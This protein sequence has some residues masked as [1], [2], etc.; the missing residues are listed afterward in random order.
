MNSIAKRAVKITKGKFPL[1]AKNIYI[2]FGLFYPQMI[3]QLNKK[4]PILVRPR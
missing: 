4:N 3:L 2:F 1:Y